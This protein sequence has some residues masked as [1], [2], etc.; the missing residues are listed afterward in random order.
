MRFLALLIPVGS[1]RQLDI[2]STGHAVRA[3]TGDHDAEVTLG[4]R[5]GRADVTS[6]HFDARRV[7]ALLP[8]AVGRCRLKRSNAGF[9]EFEFGHRD[10]LR[11]TSIS[12]QCGRNGCDGSDS[13]AGKR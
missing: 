5:V 12:S 4:V 2:G 9:K 10:I 1:N 11:H 13:Q 6:R 3:D 8:V 7:L